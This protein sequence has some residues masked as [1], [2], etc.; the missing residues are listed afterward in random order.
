MLIGKRR[1]NVRHKTYE[2]T[3]KEHFDSLDKVD[4][5]NDS[6]SLTG[7]AFGDPMPDRSALYQKQ[8]SDEERKGESDNG[9]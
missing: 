2:C 8:H 3:M 9:T 5:V 7:K 1:S 6:R 4:Y